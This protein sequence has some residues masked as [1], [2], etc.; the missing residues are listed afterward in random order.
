MDDDDGEEQIP[1]SKSGMSAV[2][3]SWCS[4]D[5]FLFFSDELLYCCCWFWALRK[6]LFLLMNFASSVLARDLPLMNLMLSFYIVI[7]LGPGLLC[8]Y[9]FL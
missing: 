6:T 5:P 1:P 8:G 3:G 4:S 2:W 9:D 7:F